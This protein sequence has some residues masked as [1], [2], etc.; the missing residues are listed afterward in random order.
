MT[1]GSSTTI[2][3]PAAPAAPTTA[4]NMSDYVNNYP[5]L[6]ALEQQYNPQQAQ[7]QYDISEK[8]GPAYAQLYK[9]TNE[10]LYPKT[11]SIQEYLTGD[12]MSKMESGV[13]KAMQELYLDKL[14]AEVGDNAGSGI[15]GDY[16]SRRIIGQSEDYKN[17]YANQLLSL[18]GRQP[19]GTY[20]NPT[21]QN[22]G[23]GYNYGQVANNNTQ[24]YGSYASLYG[25]MYGANQQAAAAGTQGMYGLLGAGLQT[26]GAMY[27]ASQ[28]AKMAP[29][30]AS[31]APMLMCW[32][33][34][35]IFGGWS[36]PKTMR[37][38]Y[39]IINQSPSWFRN[40]YAKYGERFAK[41]ISNKPIFKFILKPLFEYF[42]SHS[43]GA[44]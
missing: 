2:Q 43:K 5:A 37:A 30:M 34:S 44:M 14:R 21:Y 41:F 32:V 26:G 19:L 20:A 39:Y 3:Q 7:L 9:T 15:A 11:A 22:A 8:L 13:P 31:M 4:Q 40:L 23:E 24:G 10:Q 27:G 28:M 16:I 38:R 42:A 35:E 17:Y 33:A 29:M 25:N 12:A 36:M 1:M 18:A 6:M